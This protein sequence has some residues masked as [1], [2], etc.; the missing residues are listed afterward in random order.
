MC[1]GLTHPNGDL[2]TDFKEGDYVAVYAEG[3][4]HCLAIG[5]AMM[6]RDKMYTPSPPT[7]PTSSFPSSRSENK[8]H[9]IENIHTCGDGLW[10]IGEMD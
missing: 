4:E 3:R 5:R 10:T 9:G 2:S 1:P 8:G 6:S 7:F